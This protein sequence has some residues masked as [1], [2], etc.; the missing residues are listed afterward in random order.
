[1]LPSDCGCDWLCGVDGGQLS[2]DVFDDG[3]VGLRD[4]S[5]VEGLDEDGCGEAASQW[6]IASSRGLVTAIAGAAGSCLGAIELRWYNNKEADV[7]YKSS[8]RL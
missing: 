3:C 1:M 4:P 7:S 8:A 2:A 5:E 6:S